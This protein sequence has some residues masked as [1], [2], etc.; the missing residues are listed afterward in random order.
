[1]DSLM[2]ERTSLVAYVVALPAIH[3]ASS[4]A[5]IQDDTILSHREKLLLIALGVLTALLARHQ[6][7]LRLLTRSIDADCQLV[8]DQL[9]IAQR[10]EPVGRLASGVAHDFSNILSVVRGRAE[11]LLMSMSKCSVPGRD[12]ALTSRPRSRER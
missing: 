7:F 8:A 4:V 10:M 3:F 5:G 2:P 6:Y 11:L 1:M 12:S 9:Q